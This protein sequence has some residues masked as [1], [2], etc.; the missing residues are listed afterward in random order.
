MNLRKDHLFDRNNTPINGNLL[1]PLPPRVH[2]LA[3]RVAWGAGFKLFS[4][5]N[6]QKCFTIVQVFDKV[7]ARVGTAARCLRKQPQKT[8][9][10]GCLGS[11]NDEERSEVRYVV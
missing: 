6:R 10:N 5:H 3:R 7:A 4:H 1:V 2:E 8:P 9:N 11:R